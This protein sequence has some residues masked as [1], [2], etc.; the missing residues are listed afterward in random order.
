[1]WK[2]NINIKASS[3][4]SMNE[5]LYSFLMFIPFSVYSIYTFFI[6][7]FPDT[8]EPNPPLVHLNKTRPKAPAKRPPNK[9]VSWVHLINY[10]RVMFNDKMNAK[11]NGFYASL[12]L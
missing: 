7:H 1:M 6:L 8:A 4:R 11:I 2:K 5:T 10:L 12:V 3:V 9:S